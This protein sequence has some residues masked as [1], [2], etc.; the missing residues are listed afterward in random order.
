M[1]DA[2]FQ[3]KSCVLSS[4]CEEEEVTT[5]SFRF[6]SIASSYVGNFSSGRGASPPPPP[7]EDILRSLQSLQRILS[8]VLK[9]QG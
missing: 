5:S 3:L 1:R 2:A 7:K 9:R 4:R 6:A 8:N